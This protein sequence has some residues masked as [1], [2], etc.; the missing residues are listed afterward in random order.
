MLQSQTAALLDRRSGLY[1][2]TVECTHVQCIGVQ[3]QGRGKGHE[4]EKRSEEQE[5]LT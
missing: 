2:D 1:C 4:S 3:G 5:T